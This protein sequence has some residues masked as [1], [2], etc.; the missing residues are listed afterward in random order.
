MV[1]YSVVNKKSFGEVTELRKKIERIKDAPQIPMVL[2]SDPFVIFFNRIC[3]HFS[4]LVRSV[5]NVI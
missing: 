3:S 4:Y 2:V 1:V 5:T